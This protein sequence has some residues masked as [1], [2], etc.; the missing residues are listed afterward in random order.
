MPEYRRGS[1]IDVEDMQ[2][3]MEKA[4]NEQANQEYTDRELKA[5]TQSYKKLFTGLLVNVSSI[6]YIAILNGEKAGFGG[7]TL[8]YK[9]INALFVKPEYMSQGVGSDLLELL[10]D[11]AR[12]EGLDGLSVFASINAV[13]FYENSGYRKYSEERIETPDGRSVPSVLMTKEFEEGANVPCEDIL[14]E[15]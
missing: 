14:F 5:L 9:N 13:G 8:T 15:L 1:M 7:V 11:E 6:V 3:I 10:E 12:D 2:S 4:L